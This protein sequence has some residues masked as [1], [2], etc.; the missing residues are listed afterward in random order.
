MMDR[1]A[2]CASVHGVTES[3]MPEWLNWTEGFQVAPVVK[4]NN[5]NPPGSAYARDRGSIP[6]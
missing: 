1:E 3:D 6:T 4:N 5:N 2:W